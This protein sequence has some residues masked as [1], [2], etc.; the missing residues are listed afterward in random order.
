MLKNL[1]Y[2]PLLLN[3]RLIQRTDV[4]SQLKNRTRDFLNHGLKLYSSIFWQNKI[5]IFSTKFYRS[6]L[7][8]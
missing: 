1:L 8:T 2:I 4:T 3:E 6:L 5:K 7:E